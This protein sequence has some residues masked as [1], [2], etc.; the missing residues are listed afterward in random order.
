MN[1]QKNIHFLP[2]S[3]AVKNF[4]VFQEPARPAG[5]SI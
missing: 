1:M 4:S 2:R 5:V 3:P